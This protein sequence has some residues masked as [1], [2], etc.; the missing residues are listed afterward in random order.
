[1]SE[2]KR[3]NANP[4][5]RFFIDMLVRDIAIEPAIVELVDNSLDGARRIR[6][7][8]EA[9]EGTC[10]IRV[11]FDK[12]EFRIEDT[13]GGISINDAKNYC[14]RFGRDDNRELDLKTG[15]GVFG[16]GMK[17]AL[18][19]MGKVFDIESVTKTES[20]SLH[21]DVDEW[22]RDDNSYW[23]FQFTTI[24][25]DQDN[26]IEKCGTKIVVSKLHDVIKNAF[27]NP[28]FRDSFF[29]YVQMRSSA[30]RALKVNVI[31]NGKELQYADQKI[32][33]SDRFKPYV[34]NISI[35]GVNIRI[36]SACAR[37]GEPQKAGWYIQ[38]NGRTVVFAN[39]DEI[40]GWGTDGVRAFHPGFAS[41]RGYVY[42]ESDDLEKLPWNTTKTGVDVSSKYYQIALNEM[43]ECAKLYVTWKDRVDDFVKNDAEGKI[44]V[45]DVFDG[46]EVGML[47]EEVGLYSKDNKQFVFPKLDNSLFPVPRE[48]EATISFRVTKKKIEEAKNYLGNIKMTNKELG[49]KVFSYFYEREIE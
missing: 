34:K 8:N 48:P 30:I 31:V 18:F 28:I 13:C 10:E 43:K 44:E 3:I 27:G 22:L 6:R 45:K 36:M 38:C 20:F 2:E 46:R 12:E 49:E 11:S 4:T 16:I 24:K 29:R 33:F 25:K 35:D 14:F 5:K 9:Y 26:P 47:S 21:I 23:E 39:Q 41:F 15:T 1:M 40:T 17:R 37:M 7:D 42:F 19:R 32:L